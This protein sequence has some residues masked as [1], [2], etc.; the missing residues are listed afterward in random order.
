MHYPGSS[1]EVKSYLWKSVC[2]PSLTYG[3]ESITL[4]N[5]AIKALDSLQGCLIKQC[6]GISK[7]SHHTHLCQAMRV[8]PV[9]ETI[10]QKVLGLW[11]NVFR[12]PS[13][14]QHLCSHWLSLYIVSGVV[15]P[16]TLLDRILKLGVSPTVAALSHVE[17]KRTHAAN[18]ITDT[19]FNLVRHE[20]FIKPWSV[21]YKMTVLLTRS[22]S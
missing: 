11:H 16:G 13:P 19:L 21:E 7:T 5:Q 1:S 4:S 15:I 12:K 2:L 18:G 9:K 10:S 6:L 8:A 22:F 20:H 14:L 3:T 17:R